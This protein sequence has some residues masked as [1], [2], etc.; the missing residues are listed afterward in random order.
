M[1]LLQKLQPVFAIALASF[2]LK[3]K[4]NKYFALWASVAILGGYFLTFGFKIPVID[5]GSNTS[6]SALF[7]LIAAFSFGSSTVF[8]KMILQ[9]FNFATATFYR[10]G[11][12]ALIMLLYTLITG[13][14][15][16]FTR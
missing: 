6:L 16:H 13:T 14:L 8:S 12:T 1:V 11:F 2:L 10:Y 3:E 9:K 7:A 4:L 15:M 5:T